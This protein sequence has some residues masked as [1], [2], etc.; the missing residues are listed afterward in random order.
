MIKCSIKRAGHFVSQ[1][2]G[3]STALPQI[4]QQTMKDSFQDSLW[5]FQY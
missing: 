2:E 4:Q 5:V 3:V 1:T